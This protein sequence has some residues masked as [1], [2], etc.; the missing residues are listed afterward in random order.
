VATEVRTLARVAAPTGLEGSPVG[1]TLTSAVPSRRQ[2]GP[3][4]ATALRTP[5]SAAS[6][7]AI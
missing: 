7:L 2:A 3:A 5:G 6:R 1:W 4:G